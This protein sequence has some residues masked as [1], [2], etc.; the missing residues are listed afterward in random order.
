MNFL[1]RHRKIHS[2]WIS[3]L[4]MWLTLP[5][6]FMIDGCDLLCFL[7]V[8]CFSCSVMRYHATDRRWLVLANSDKFE[9][10]LADVHLVHLSGFKLPSNLKIQPQN[11]Y[12]CPNCSS[13]FSRKNNLY[14]HIKFECGQ[15]PRFGCP[16]CEYAS[17]K[18]SNVRAH[19]RRK[20]HGYEIGVISLLQHRH[21]RYWETC[22]LS[23]RSPR[24]LYKF[25]T[26]FTSN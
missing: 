4:S 1:A 25:V 15:L 16:Y 2:T 12:P 13:S 22:S 3:S 19:I 11:K 8:S 9:R 21:R 18:S 6:F 14:S 10:F 20:H 23:L 7:D 17:K 5:E 26:K 24:F